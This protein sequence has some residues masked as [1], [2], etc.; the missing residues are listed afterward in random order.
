M[1]RNYFKA[2][3]RNLWSNRTY[4]F[5]N[6]AGLAIGIACASL[7]FLWVADEISFDHFNRKMDRLYF[8]MVNAVLDKG[9][10]THGSSPGVLGP[11]IEANIP[12]IANT[13]RVSEDQTRLLF[14]IG[15]KS[16]YASGKYAEPSLFSMFTIPFLEGSPKMAF[17]QLHSLVITE[18]TAMKFFGKDQGVLG[19][20]VRMDKKQDYVITGVLKDIPENSSLQ[21]EWLAP[22]Q[23]YFDQSP[24]AHFWEN[25]CLSTYVELKPNADLARINRQMYNFVQKRAPTS[26]GHVFLF[27]MKD[28][29]LRSQFANG[30]QTGGGQI[31][32]VRLFSL[33]AW[34]ILL[35]ACIN[36]MNLATA[37]SE[38]RALE[39]GVRKVLGAG[40]QKLRFQFILE[41]LIMT[42]LSTAV[43]V[44]VIALVLPSFNTL[45][46]KNLTL[47]WSRLSHWGFLGGITLIC[48][49]VAGS[50]PSLYLA[51]FNPVSVLKGFIARSA[52]A[53]L[54]RRGLVV[55]QFTVSIFLI[56]GTLV[57]YRQILH[58]KARDLGFDKDNL[59]EIDM[60]GHIAA[61]YDAIRQDLI[62]TGYV[63]DVA[64]SD[65]RTLYGGNNTDGL[66]WD[67]K[68]PG[69]RILVSWRGVSPDFISTSGLRI[70]E[71]RDF[72]PTDTV[73]E[74]QPVI[75]AN[76]LITESFAR[77]MGPGSA[78]GQRIYDQ[79]DSQLQAT[80]VGVVHDY[81]Y[82]DLY[83]KPDPVLFTCSPPRFENTLYIRT[84]K[85]TDPVKAIAR[86]GAV[87]KADNPGYPFEFRF[88]DDNFNGFIQT[89]TLMGKLSRV[90]AAIA[91]LIS[92]L[93]LFGLAAYT[94]ER[95][96]REIGIRKVVGA[97]VPRIA[98]LLSAD[99][100]RLVAV[101]AVISFPLSWLV[102]H[103]WLDHYA[104]RTT[105]SW[106][107]F[108][109]AGVLALGIALG[110]I[111]FQAV[112]AAMA[113]PVRSLR[114]E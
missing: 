35:I 39:I 42:L 88:V 1:I 12:G 93:G 45:V 29:H 14:T 56:I 70:L 23:V 63:R 82:G 28:W 22:F 47:G 38:K 11:A 57:I 30:K 74:D 95:R 46:Q 36:F 41:A 80:V 52:G 101:S 2:F 94:A 55:L 61:H 79:N 58:I 8:V 76:V 66:A 6:I 51:S 7:I 69:A 32:Y 86:I 68:A 81:V 49:L 54:V 114:S 43:A 26:N 67:G 9:M 78:V 97:S 21:F 109:L 24:W 84:L 72:E 60:Q 33:I 108:L 71:G 15:N 17:E 25:N 53:S 50:Y 112:R 34:I 98:A 3:L 65:H 4:S 27:P 91:I 73:N 48:G 37:R 87:M 77:L 102:M 107:I 18:K 16:V 83:G 44:L 104:Y 92:C 90:F 62:S 40:K 5:L 13:C 85:G 100:L 59:V 103:Q 19:R 113:N 64:L 10:F 20:I 111:S 110:T 31:A 75:R 96:T 106:W 105:I 99:F 89:E